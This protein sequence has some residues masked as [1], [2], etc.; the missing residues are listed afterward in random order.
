MLLYEV[1]ELRDCLDD[2]MGTRKLPPRVKEPQFAFLLKVRGFNYSSMLP[3]ISQSPDYS[4]AT[5]H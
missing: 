5:R 2:E 1:L 4:K 3:V